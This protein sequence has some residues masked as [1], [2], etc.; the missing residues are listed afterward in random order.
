MT[1]PRALVIEDDRDI[2]TMFELALTAAGFAVEVAHNGQTALDRL[3]ALVP[4]M[5]L[6]DL[7]LPGVSGIDVVRA[8]K[9]DARLTTTRVIVA[10]GNP[11]MS[12]DIYDQADL[13]L[14]K[15]VSY[16]QLRDLGKRFG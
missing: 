3:Q 14:I 11:Q 7:S 1:R 5:V 4:A 10:S 13:V 2:A 12:D 15:P 8:I 16:E 6:V 9:A